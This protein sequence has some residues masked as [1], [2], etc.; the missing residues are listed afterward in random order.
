M[1]PRL[2]RDAIAAL[3]SS[4]GIDLSRLTVWNVPQ[5]IPLTRMPRGPNSSAAA[6]VSAF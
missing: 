3:D 6:L 5:T 4:V 1:R 2:I